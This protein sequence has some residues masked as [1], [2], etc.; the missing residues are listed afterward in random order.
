[1]L[2]KGMPVQLVFGADVSSKTA[3]VGDKVLLTLS[4][5]LNAGSAVV[6]KK[7]SP[8]VA[9]ILQVDKTGAG[10]LPGEI[11]FE[12]DSLDVNGVTAN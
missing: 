8:A 5:D 4:D 10:G 9:T 7:G 1:V 2:P 11:E 6:A 12:V 3:S